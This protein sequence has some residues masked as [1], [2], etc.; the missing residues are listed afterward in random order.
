M[1][2]NTTVQAGDSA[3]RFWYQNELMMEILAATIAL[4]VIW[5]VMKNIFK[6]KAKLPPG[7][8][9]YPVVGAM[10]SVA[11]EKHFNDWVRKMTEEFGKIFYF[12]LGSHNMII[13]SS[14]EGI[15]EVF[16]TKDNFFSNRPDETI[17][18]A[19][20]Q[21]VGFG[22]DIAFA[23]YEKQRNL[24]KLL[25]ENFFN[26][27]KMVVSENIR[28]REGEVHHSTNTLNPLINQ[29]GTKVPPRT[30]ERLR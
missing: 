9:N 6:S 27:S 18:K 4:L 7:P 29:A 17:Q 11:S 1:V 23:S 15:E 25:I 10:L 30:L 28:R 3:R 24:K 20:A 19:A 5:Q 22:E 13:V 12:R 14:P 2:V 26:A 8:T 21:Y 16:K